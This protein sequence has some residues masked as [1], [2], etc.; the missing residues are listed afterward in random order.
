MES[1]GNLLVTRENIKKYLKFI[2]EIV[3]IFNASIFYYLQLFR[4]FVKYFECKLS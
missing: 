2:Q 3:E 4:M 1:V